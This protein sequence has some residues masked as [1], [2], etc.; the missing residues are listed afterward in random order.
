MEIPEEYEPLDLIAI[1][2]SSQRCVRHG[3]GM[4]EDALAEFERDIAALGFEPNTRLFVTSK[5]GRELGIT[6]PMALNA[7]DFILVDGYILHVEFADLVQN[8]VSVSGD[9]PESVRIGAE[10]HPVMTARWNPPIVID[11]DR[12]A[13]DREWYMNIPPQTT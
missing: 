13:S 7:N 9:I 3:A 1:A 10:I 4:S 2:A 11:P 5:A 6:M 12:A 8:T